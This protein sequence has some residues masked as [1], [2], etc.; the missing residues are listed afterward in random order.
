MLYSGESKTPVYAVERLNSAS[1]DDTKG[2]KRHDRFY[3]G[4]RLPFA[5]RAQFEDYAGSGFDRGHMAPVGDMPG[6]DA[7]AQSFSLANMVP[8]TP[9]LNQKA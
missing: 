5:D 9:E 4:A 3:L 7:K 2:R 6:D 1:V 8:Q